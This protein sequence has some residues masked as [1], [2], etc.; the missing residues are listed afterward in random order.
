MGFEVYPQ[1]HGEGEK[2]GEPT[3]EFGWRYR[4]GNGQ[5]TAVSGEGYSREEDAQR[6]VEFFVGDVVKVATSLDVKHVEE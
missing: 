5:I 1:K 4:D 3:G 6:A 2:E